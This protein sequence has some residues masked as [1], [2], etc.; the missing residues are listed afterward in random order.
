MRYGN[1]LLRPERGYTETL[2]WGA[3]RVPGRN[4]PDTVGNPSRYSVQFNLVGQSMVDWFGR[5]WWTEAAEGSVPIETGIG[6]AQVIGT[7]TFSNN[8]G[9]RA[10]VNMT[11]EIEDT[12]DFCTDQAWLFAGEYFGDEFFKTAARL[13]SAIDGV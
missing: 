7:P 12:A 5:W 6:W 11:L 9:R 13:R 4:R 10:T 3:V 1:E 8:T 2:P